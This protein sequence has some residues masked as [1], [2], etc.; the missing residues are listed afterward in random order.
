MVA[1]L[2]KQGCEQEF[3]EWVAQTQ[4]HLLPADTGRDLDIELR[5]EGGARDQ[6]RAGIAT[7]QMALKPAAQ[8][9][10]NKMRPWSATELHAIQ[11]IVTDRHNYDIVLTQLQL[12]ISTQ[13]LKQQ[14]QKAI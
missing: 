3:R 9:E 8:Q 10:W 12:D 4:N 7:V 2:E 14:V 5:A 13:L 6:D 1:A 11:K